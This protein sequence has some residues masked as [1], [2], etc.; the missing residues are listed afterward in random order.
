MKKR[1]PKF[2][3]RRFEKDIINVCKKHYP[4]PLKCSDI[5]Y[6]VRGCQVTVQRY[7]NALCR[8]GVL[9]G[10]KIGK[11]TMYLIRK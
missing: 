1:G 9:K 5:A 11:R 8:K 2:D 7:V 3:G 4:Y 6:F 10:I